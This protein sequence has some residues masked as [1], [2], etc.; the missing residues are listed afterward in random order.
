MTAKEIHRKA[1]DKLYEDGKFNHVGG[2]FKQARPVR[3]N[4]LSIGL[5]DREP[6]RNRLR[7][8]DLRGR[9]QHFQSNS[10]MSGMDLHEVNGSNYP[11][12]PIQMIQ[13]PVDPRDILNNTNIPFDAVTPVA[14]NIT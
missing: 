9:N 5:P 3:S 11:G 14:H 8:K 6:D 12:S 1:L 2:K 10:H 4:Y 13:H 7:Q